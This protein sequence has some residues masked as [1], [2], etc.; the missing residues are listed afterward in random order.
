MEKGDV[1]RLL[2][3]ILDEHQ[4][5]KAVR[6]DDGDR[7]RVEGVRCCRKLGLPP[8]CG[9]YLHP[10]GAVDNSGRPV[11]ALQTVDL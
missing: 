3:I 5:G 7:D 6:E 8:S 10:L 1:L 11:P 2:S 4:D 9:M